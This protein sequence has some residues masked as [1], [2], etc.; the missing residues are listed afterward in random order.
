MAIKYMRSVM[1]KIFAV[2][3]LALAV[4]AALSTVTVSPSSAGGGNAPQPKCS[5]N[6]C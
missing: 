5:G 3:L 2:V 1:R 4:G 6:G